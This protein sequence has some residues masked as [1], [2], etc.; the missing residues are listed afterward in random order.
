MMT[1]RWFPQRPPR[2]FADH[3]ANVLRSPRMSHGAR[4][5]LVA[6]SL[7]ISVVLNFYVRQTRTVSPPVYSEEDMVC[8][9]GD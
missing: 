3:P 4:W 7:L 9:P 6:I 1:R 5:R 2:T 8:R